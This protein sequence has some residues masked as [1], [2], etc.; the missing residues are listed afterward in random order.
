M[1]IYRHKENK[2]LYTIEHLILDI[3]FSN[4]NEFAGIYAYPYNRQC[5]DVIMFRNKNHHECKT[6]IEQ[7][8]KIVA[9]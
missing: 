5:D 3:R 4:L 1:N 6:F 8:F 9:Y 7:N 2:K